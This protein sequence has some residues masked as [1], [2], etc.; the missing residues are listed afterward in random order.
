MADAFRCDMCGASIPEK[1]PA[2]VRSLFFGVLAG[3]LIAQTYAIAAP[4]YEQIAAFRPTPTTPGA[5]LFHH[6]DGSFYGM[7]FDSIYRITPAGELTAFAP[8]RGVGTV[9][10]DAADFVETSDGRL[11]AALNYTSPTPRSVVVRFDPEREK[12]KIIAR[13]PLP[14]VPNSGLTDDGLGFLWGTTRRFGA[15]GTPVI[16][17]VNQLSHVI[18]VVYSFSPRAT[19]S[20][21][22]QEP[23]L[24]VGEELWGGNADE[25]GLI[26]VNARTNAVTEI[27]RDDPRL[28]STARRWQ[29]VR[30]EAGNVWTTTARALIKFSAGDKTY[31]IV[32]ELGPDKPLDHF[33]PHR[34]VRDGLGFMWGTTFERPENSFNHVYVFKINEETG[35]LVVVHEFTGL[36]G[37]PQE[38]GELTSDGNGN[39]WATA[40]GLYN[41]NGSVFKVDIATGAVTIVDQFHDRALGPPGA[42]LVSDGMGNL[43]GLL[44]G[45]PGGAGGAVFKIDTS[46]GQLTILNA[47]FGA[48]LNASSGLY[49]GTQLV[50]GADGNLWGAAS[51]WSPGGLGF[52]ES[53][54]NGFIYKVDPVTWTTTRVIEFPEASAEEPGAHPVNGLTADPFGQLWGIATLVAA[55]GGMTGG[56]VFKI[57]PITGQLQKLAAVPEF[58]GLAP[59][60]YDDVDSMWGTS[61]SG[62]LFKVN[63]HTGAFTVLG[64]TNPSWY[65]NVLVSDRHGFLWGTR[66]APR[67]HRDDIFKINVATG[68][69]TRVA[70]LNAA[71][72]A[73][74]GLT[75]DRGG[76]MWGILGIGPRGRYPNNNLV[77]P[78][79]GSVF[80]IDVDTGQFANVRDFP[81]RSYPNTGVV[82]SPLVF[83]G[84]SGF[85]GATIDSGVLR[86]GT[87]FKVTP[88]SFRTLFTFTGT[89]GNVPGAFPVQN[90]NRSLI[91]LHSDGNLYGSTTG[92]GILENG[93]PAGGGVFYRI[94]FGPTPV[95]LPAAEIT[96]TSA[97]LHGTINPHG[98]FT[99]VTFDIGLDP[100]LKTFWTVPAGKLG[101]RT[102]PHP[103]EALI[104]NLDAGTVYYFRVNG[105]SSENE[106]PQH[107]A[108]LSLQTQS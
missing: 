52:F 23:L 18:T 91:T 63:I 22:Q 25:P 60:T 107:G 93:K 13:L 97:I 58:L 28:F 103:V 108:V 70:F 55:T 54:G 21:R 87:I 57:D 67:P 36:P 38:A 94:R 2:M 8:I 6:S 79:F 43:W 32:T 33:G 59:L 64:V 89:K 15:N 83:D 39:L 9:P 27:G 26:V 3:L 29:L 81:G 77:E 69:L 72:R 78:G 90:W 99:R 75:P 7:D 44:T 45:P 41:E 24:R 5:S 65:E 37:E 61:G 101:A 88:T 62:K 11:W 82:T 17:K 92:G 73:V 102:R 40:G 71:F 66:L 98:A 4:A 68:E 86:L 76:N 53:Q 56:F 30:D 96:A 104:E 51:Q 1:K 10:L 95:T 106:H 49:P 42:Y 80:R 47:R 34:L 84:A 50:S 19:L 48:N 31:R 16:Y 105:E 85:Y 100:E 20:P 74:W 14:L 35:E 46:T 12:L